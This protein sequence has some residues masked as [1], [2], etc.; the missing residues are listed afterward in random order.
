MT[1]AVPL[2]LSDVTAR[3][4]RSDDDQRLVLYGVPWHTYVLLN[5]AFDQPGVKVSYY[6]GALEIMTKSPRHEVGKKF[7]ARLL[8]LWALER[9]VPLY[10]Y[11]ETTFREELEQAGVEPDECYTVG[12]QLRTVPDLAIEVVVS[13]G[14]LD[15]LPIYRALGVREVWIFENGAVTLHG[16]GRK[17]YRIAR[18][19]ALLP[20]LDLRL[21]ARHL[22]EPDQHEAVRA[23][24]DALRAKAKGKTKPKTKP[25][26]KSSR[27]RRKGSGPHRG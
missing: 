16:L 22:A 18:R 21:L 7:L 11:G 23:F 20:E 2:G 12:E 6:R 15:K 13:T 3:A 24:R 25:K 8:E 10:G 26:T 27:N 19:S 9:D 1:V 4:G 5:D 14:A 17:G